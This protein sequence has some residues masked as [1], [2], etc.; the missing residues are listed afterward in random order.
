MLVSLHA[1]SMFWIMNTDAK[2]VTGFGT[3]NFQKLVDAAMK[4]AGGQY[5]G[6]W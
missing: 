5:G 6:G 2:T 4:K 3:P 1:A